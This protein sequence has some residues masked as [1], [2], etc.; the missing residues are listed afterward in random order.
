VGCFG[1]AQWRGG[2]VM[3]LKKKVLLLICILA[4]SSL[5]ACEFIDD[6][7]EMGKKDMEWAKENHAFTD[8]RSGVDISL[9]DEEKSDEET[10][11]DELKIG[12]TASFSIGDEGGTVDVTI[13]NW[14]VGW[15]DFTEKDLIYFEVE[16][17]NT[18]SNAIKISPNI[19][20]VYADN[21]VVDTTLK[22]DSMSVSSLDSG[23]K[24]SGK[25][26]AVVNVDSVERLEVQ[27]DNTV[28]VLKGSESKDS[29]TSEEK[30]TEDKNATSTY[31]YEAMTYA[32]SYEGWGG[33]SISFSAYSSVEDDV[34]GVA[35]I[36][37]EGEFVSS[38]PVHIC[39]DRGDW[40]GSDYDQFYVM[41]CDGYNEYLGFY[42]SEGKSMLDYN[43][44]NSN[45]DLLEMTEQY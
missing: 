6:V 2:E 7:E 9:F 28:W 33:Y 21:C 38:Q 32:G 15:D 27:I 45:Y 1:F 39:T 22:S 18:G 4:M 16:M 24:A 43:G 5:S 41:H 36:Y 12:D 37:Y 31:D 35:E 40:S 25:V 8:G 17:K 14:G 19:F 44:P 13:S 20:S 34:I 30:T 3:R 10:I 23:R 42:K 11:R 26:Y 29:S